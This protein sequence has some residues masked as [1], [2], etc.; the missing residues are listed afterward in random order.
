M[1]GHGWIDSIRNKLYVTGSS[2]AVVD[3]TPD[4]GIVI[5]RRIGKFDESRIRIWR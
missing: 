3:K 4:I 5:E 1:T 2:S